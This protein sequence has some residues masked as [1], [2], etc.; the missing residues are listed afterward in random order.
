VQAVEPGTLVVLTG[1]AEHEGE[2]LE[3]E[4]YPSAHIVQLLP[5]DRED[6]GGQA[7]KHSVAPEAE[8][9]KRKSAPLFPVDP[10]PGK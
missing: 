9:G 1:Q 4:K 5:L 7:R 3:V 2:L 8:M 6:P 10:T